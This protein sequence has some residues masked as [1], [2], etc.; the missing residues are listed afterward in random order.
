MLIPTALASDM[1]DATEGAVDGHIAMMKLGNAISS[2]IMKNAMIMFGWVGIFTP[3]PPAPPIPDAIIIATG[4]I[5]GIMISL[6]QSGA[7]AQP[8]ALMALATQIRTGVAMGLYMPDAPWSCSPGSMATIPP[9]SLSLAGNNRQMVFLSLA[10]QICTWIQTFIP[11]VPCA[12]THT[13]GV[14][15]IGTATPTVIL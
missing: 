2:Y 6:T 14:P 7:T 13:V 8:A 9:L 3:P 10:T 11:T 4:K 1:I 5:Q 15:Y 12:G